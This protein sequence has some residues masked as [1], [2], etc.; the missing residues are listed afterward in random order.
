[1]VDVVGKMNKPS[2]TCVLKRPGSTWRSLR[3]SIIYLQCYRTRDV[4]KS[5][6]THENLKTFL[7]R[8]AL[9]LSHVGR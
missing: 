9:N 3:P 2:K 4:S 6:K 1:M 7:Q 5:E 8:A